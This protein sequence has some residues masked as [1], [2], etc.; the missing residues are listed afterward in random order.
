MS[1]PVPGPTSC[2]PP[3]VGLVLLLA[4]CTGAQL[5]PDTDGDGLTDAQEVLFCTDP[6]D[7]DTDGDGLRD[8]EDAQPLPGDPKLLLAPQDALRFANGSWQLS[9][10]AT[11]LDHLDRPLLVDTLR[12]KTD[13]GRLTPFAPRPAEQGVFEALLSSAQSGVAHLEV[14]LDRAEAPCRGGGP[15]QPVCA[16]LPVFLG[17]T[18]PQPG[19]NPSPY[20]EELTDKLTVF[21]LD[22]LT[23]GSD[24]PP[25]PVP[26]AHVRV[27]DESGDF[28]AQG[29]TD[30]EGRAEI[31]LPAGRRAVTVTIAA[32]GRR[33]VT[34]HDVRAAVVAAA[35]HPLAPEHPQ[36]RAVL[37]SE[38][39]GQ[40]ATGS[41]TGR[42]TGFDGAH[43]GPVFPLTAP[44]G[45]LE[46]LEL[47]IAIVH[48]AFR[49]QQLS[50]VSVG[51]LLEMSDSGALGPIPVPSNMA[52]YPD[53]E[54]FTLAGL[55]PG[56]TLIFA[57]AGRAQ[58]VLDTLQDPYALRFTPLALGMARVMVKAG[59]TKV[60]DIPLA[61]DLT[62]GAPGTTRID[63]DF[64]RLPFDAATGE[65][66]PEG[67]LMP[68]ID[69]GGMGFIFTAV[70]S[71]YN[72]HEA[73]PIEERWLTLSEILPDASHPEAERLA[74]HF[75]AGFAFSRPRIVGL[76][77]RSSIRGA[78]PPGIVTA[79][80]DPPDPPAGASRLEMNTPDVWLPLPVPLVPRPPDPP[81]A[82]DDVG[83]DLAGHIA[84]DPP[85]GD[86]AE[87]VDL[88]VVRLGYMTPPPPSF[89]PGYMLG[90]AR[91]HPLWDFYVPA[92]RTEIRLPQVPEAA[93]GWP[94]LLVNPAPSDGTEAL[95]R[96]GERTIEIE[97]NAVVLGAAGKSFDYDQDF[98]VSDINLHASHLSQDSYLVQVPPAAGPAR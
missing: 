39:A 73:M 68:I 81:A 74:K 36:A 60:A 94:P 9:L 85:A 15:P 88:Y 71:R 45:S 98:L 56:E 97:L 79:I 93:L 38:A 92:P 52:I 13:L 76:A 53:M 89:A 96:Y 87:R 33:Y 50:S 23:V 41:V 17:T 47:N 48:A 77:G 59:E 70:D 58:G 83:G 8:G 72:Y 66:F 2:L 61:I 63:V 67:L 35:L 14:C 80:L 3:A 64:G 91:S 42:V 28:L 49:N 55:P 27:E 78:D 25:I 86:A 24:L 19:L 95:L 90:G 57:L 84:W 32:L 30:A 37:A 43:G 16:A 7:P 21:A 54:G 10:K 44:G 6:R 51:N 31:P 1:R 22:G 20:R 69:T 40:P 29:T 34:Y 75:T 26:D 65:V 62:P 18:L 4:G 82:L 12:G 11:V 5:G 46:E